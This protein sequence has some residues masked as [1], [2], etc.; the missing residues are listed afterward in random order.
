MVTPDR[1]TEAF[2][3]H[4]AGLL[5]LARDQGLALG[6]AE[7]LLTEVQLQL[8]D[9]RCPR[10]RCTAGPFT[11]EDKRCPKHDELLYVP[12]DGVEDRAKGKSQD[13][14][15][16]YLKQRVKW[17][18]QDAR[19]RRATQAE[20][21]K[22]HD[23][24]RDATEIATRRLALTRALDNL[25]GEDRQIV[26]RLYEHRARREDVAQEMGISVATLDRRVAHI[27]KQLEVIRE[28]ATPVYR[29]GLTAP[30]RGADEQRTP[31][32]PSDLAARAR[33]DRLGYR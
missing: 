29:G 8:L 20:Y 32:L 14:V 27:R 19:K 5:R 30:Q 17:A 18:A 24:I 22:Q 31:R 12:L 3:Q 25:P 6:D 21:E 16:S 7:D 26:R 2:R 13:P 1:L 10:Q 28:P 9:K 11:S 33:Q 15:L 23:D 4:R